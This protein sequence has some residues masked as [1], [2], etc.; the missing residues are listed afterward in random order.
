LSKNEGKIKKIQNMNKKNRAEKRK[1]IE[2]ENKKGKSLE[3]SHK[4]IS[5]FCMIIRLWWWKAG[6]T[7]ALA[8]VHV[9]AEEERRTIERSR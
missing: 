3:I 1:I 6:S 5:I 8:L 7:K 2:N 4:R 9:Q